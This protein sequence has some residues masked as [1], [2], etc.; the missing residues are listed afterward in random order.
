MIRAL[1][2]RSVL[3]VPL[4]ARGRILG[5]ITLIWAESGR[6]YRA[7]DVELSQELAHRAALAIDNARLFQEAQ[8][9]NAELEVRVADRTL[10]LV[11][12]TLELANEMDERQ[13]T[14]LALQKSEMMLSSVFEFAPDAIFLIDPDGRIARVNQ[15]AELLFGFS[16]S[17]LVGKLIDELVPMHFRRSHAGKRRSYMREPITRSMGAG[18]DLFALRK[19]GLEFPVDIMLS[20]VQTE[21]GERVICAVR[22]ISEQK[23]LQ[24]DLA[25]THRRLF[26]SVEAERLRISQDLHDGPIQDLYGVALYMQM[27]RDFVQGTQQLEEFQ[28]AT[29]SIQA[30]IQ[31]LRVICGELRPPVL[32]Q[33]GLKKAIR[34][35]LGKVRENNPDVVI[36]SDLMNDG[37]ALTER[38]RLALYRVYQNAISN[39]IRHAGANHIWVDFRLEEGEIRLEIKDNGR[40]FTVPGKWIDLAREGHFGLVGMTERVEAIG[41]H[42]QVESEKGQGTTV[43]VVVPLDNSVLS[44]VLGE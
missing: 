38:T 14:E 8:V 9:S 4:I 21:E 30:V 20:P 23:R 17:E 33:F 32:S 2:L 29:A 34:S 7:R 25:E 22:N 6:Q 43:R 28:A 26:E 13:K 11:E 3:I 41:G 35:H 16:R 15:Q 44:A 1:G 24:A 18:L 10:E 19:D 40:G 37:L 39:V 27:L 36:E 12:A 42:M 31:S 5:A